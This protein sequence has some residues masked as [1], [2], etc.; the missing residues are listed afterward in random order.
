MPVLR[1]ESG[2]LYMAINYS[3]QGNASGGWTAERWSKQQFKDAGWS[4]VEGEIEGPSGNDQQVH[5]LVGKH[6]KKGEVYKL[7]CNKY[8][9]PFPIEPK[10]MK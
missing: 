10:Q 2:Y 1:L 3:Y 8:M 4:P 6:V 5:E 7:R 9:P